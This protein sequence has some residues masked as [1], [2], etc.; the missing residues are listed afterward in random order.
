MFKAELMTG[1]I[2]T[3]GNPLSRVTAGSLTD[4]GYTV[5]LSSADPYTLTPPFTAPS[6]AR[7]P[8]LLLDDRWSGPLYEIDPAGGVKRIPRP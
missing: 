2:N 8:V 7:A 5:N 6:A 1:F 4:L 3:G